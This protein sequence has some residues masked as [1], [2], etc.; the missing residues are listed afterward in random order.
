MGDS[1]AGVYCNFG[2]AFV[3][4]ATLGLQ[5]EDLRTR[6]AQRHSNQRDSATMV[7]HGV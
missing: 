1:Q 4:Q 7:R 2:F 3:T 6:H 5:R